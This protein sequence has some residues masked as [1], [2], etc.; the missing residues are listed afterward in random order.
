VAAF[1]GGAWALLLF[2]F[3]ALVGRAPASLRTAPAKQVMA[4]ARAAETGEDAPLDQSRMASATVARFAASRRPPSARARGSASREPDL[5]SVPSRRPK[6]PSPS[7][8][9]DD[10]H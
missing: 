2:P 9:S 5:T 6:I 4:S 7:D 1:A 3:P 8:Q 10:P